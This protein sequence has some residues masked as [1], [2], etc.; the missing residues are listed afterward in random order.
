MDQFIQL[1]NNYLFAGID[2]RAW[3]VGWQGSFG[4]LPKSSEYEGQIAILTRATIRLSKLKQFWKNV[5]G[6]ATKMA[7]ADGLVTSYGI[8]EMPLIKQATFSIWQ[9]KDAMRSFAYQTNEHQEVIQ[10]TRR[11]DWYSEDM[12]VRFKITG[13]VGSLNG[14]NPLKGKI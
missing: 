3:I 12:F 8:G 9:S 10:R 4:D 13:C 5:D 2:R 6:V 14:I 7:K 11:N 1:R